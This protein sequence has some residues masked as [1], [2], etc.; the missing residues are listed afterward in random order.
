MLHVGG[1]PNPKVTYCTAALRAFLKW[2]KYRNGNQISGYQGWGLWD[3]E[4]RA[5]GV[6]TRVTGGSRQRWN[7]PVSRLYQHHCLGYDAL[8]GMQ[9]LRLRAQWLRLHLKMQGTRIRSVVG[10]LRS[11]RSRGEYTPHTAPSEPEHRTRESI[12]ELQLRSYSAK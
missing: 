1:A 4:Q 11:H 5:E 6:S 9:W 3:R 7:C 10:E 12:H 8:L 2:Q